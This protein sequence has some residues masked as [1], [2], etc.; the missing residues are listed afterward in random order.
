MQVNEWV[1]VKLSRA[2][3][4]AEGFYAHISEYR[5]NRPQV[6]M[7]PGDLKIDTIGQAIGKDDK[8]FAIYPSE[9][10]GFAAL[11]Q[12]IR[13]MYNGSKIY[14]SEMT[15]LEVAQHYTTSERETWAAIVAAELNVSQDT[16]LK[17]L[18]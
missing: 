4:H 10:T 9:E 18:T 12:Q 11:R 14:N 3:A 7:N 2:I 15:I 5:R 1:I 13:L 8:G 6:N 17:E 16:K